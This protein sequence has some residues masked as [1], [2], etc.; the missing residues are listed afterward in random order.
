MNVLHWH[1]VDQQSFPFQSKS[2]PKLWS[3]AYSNEERYTERDI[4]TIVEY[5]RARG[6]RVMVEFDVPGHAAS[7]C[8][9]GSLP[10]LSF[11]WTSLLVDASSRAK[12]TL[13]PS[14]TITT[15]TTTTPNRIPR[16]LPL[17]DLPDAAQRGQQQDV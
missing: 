12:L 13:A 10:R 1:I 15:A 17:H 2:Y 7:W 4:A 6:V 11:L 3:G 5:A 9:G 8:A 14:P 16:D